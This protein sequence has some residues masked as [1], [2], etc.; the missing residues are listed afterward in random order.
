MLL[1][2]LIAA[3]PITST[4]CTYDEQVRF[5]YYLGCVV[6]PVFTGQPCAGPTLP[7]L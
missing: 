1:V 6:A 3:L 7:G 2:G 5:F 4:A